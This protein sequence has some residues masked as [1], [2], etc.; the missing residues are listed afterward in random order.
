TPHLSDARAIGPLEY[1]APE[2]G[3]SGQSI[4]PA[5]DLYALGAIL[6]R[7]ITGHGVFG[8]LV[9]VDLVRAKATRPAPPLSTGRSD[10]VARRLESVVGRALA[11]NLEQRYKHADD[12]LTDLLALPRPGEAEAPA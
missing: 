6:Y 10:W 9:G 1:M 8:S 12:M 3:L 11:R 2:Q 7:A 4:T 5:A